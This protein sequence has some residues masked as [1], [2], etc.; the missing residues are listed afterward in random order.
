MRRGGKL[1][2][3]RPGSFR[4]AAHSRNGRAAVNATQIRACDV[5]IKT[6]PGPS[7]GVA[8]DHISSSRAAP[9]V[10]S[11]QMRPPSTSVRAIRGRV[12]CGLSVTDRSGIQQIRF[13]RILCHAPDR[14]G[15]AIAITAAAAIRVEKS[16]CLLK[17]DAKSHHETPRAACTLLERAP[18]VI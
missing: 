16:R 9:G 17:C 18:A 4:N 6:S 5:P 12:R 13:A 3:S 11:C 1:Q 10:M 14:R 15:S 7:G 2:R 8:I